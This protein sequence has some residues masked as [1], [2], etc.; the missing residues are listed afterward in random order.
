MAD[1]LLC[2]DFDGTLV[3]HTFPGVG[4]PIENAFEVVKEAIDNGWG[5]ILYTCRENEGNYIDRQYLADAIKYCWEQHQVWFDGV[6]ETPLE[7]DFRDPS[8][9]N[10]KPYATFYIDDKMI[11]GL[12]DWLDIRKELIKYDKERY[13]IEWKAL[14]N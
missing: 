11:G 3:T 10:R 14:E 6:N 9:L 13:G 12:P 7:S 4:E 1:R 8:S 5:V 2:I